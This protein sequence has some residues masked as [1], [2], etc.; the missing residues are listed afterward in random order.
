MSNKFFKSQDT[1]QKNSLTEFFNSKIAEK[2]SSQRKLEE[3]TGYSQGRISSYL[4]GKTPLSLENITVLCKALNV[5]IP[6]ELL[7]EAQKGV[8][9][10]LVSDYSEFPVPTI[11]LGSG[12]EAVRRVPEVGFGELELYLTSNF[13]KSNWSGPMTLVEVS[14]LNAIEFG[15]HEYPIVIVSNAR[16]DTLAIQNGDKILSTHLDR[17]HWHYLSGV[18]II[19]SK[20]GLVMPRRVMSSTSEE[21]IV[22]TLDMGKSSIS[23]DDIKA[24]WT[25][26][27]VL[28]P[29]PI[30]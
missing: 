16:F 7:S 21:I 18:F 13:Y 26:H 17:I 19:V 11:V 27:F 1:E 15:A 25:V 2:K 29:R 12:N 5:P 20:T 22:Q 8:L 14:M 28:T 6:F 9:K 10:T 30:S 3:I 4:T 24:M 23:K